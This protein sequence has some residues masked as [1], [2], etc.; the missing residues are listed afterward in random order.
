MSGERVGGMDSRLRFDAFFGGKRGGT[1]NSAHFFAGREVHVAMARGCM[2]YAMVLWYSMM[3]EEENGQKI[4][5][6][7]P[8]FR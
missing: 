7:F 8:S 6:L 2:I 4:I 1:L 5:V 3:Y